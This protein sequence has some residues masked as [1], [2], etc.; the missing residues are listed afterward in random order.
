MSSLREMMLYCWIDIE[1][2]Y[3]ILEFNDIKFI[4]AE[5]WDS[6][7]N[8]IYM[9]DALEIDNWDIFSSFYEWRDI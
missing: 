6:L 4:N 3:I 5:C 9:H 7:L 8:M 2:K 1:F